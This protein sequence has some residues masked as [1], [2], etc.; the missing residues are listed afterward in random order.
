MND[1]ME[2]TELKYEIIAAYYAQHYEELK[3]FVGKRILFADA[4]EDIV[5]N[6]F[7]RLL[8]L[9]KMI[10][11]VT[12]PCL[13]YTV[14]RNLIFDYWRHH[15]K[16]DEYE[17]YL[18]VEL[19]NGDSGKDTA[20]SVYSVREITE[21]LEQG[22]AR[23]TEKQQKIY[24]MNMLENKAVKEISEELGLNYKTVE[25]KLGSARKV[26][27]TYLKRMMA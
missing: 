13:V 20:E 8:T 24:A 17:H 1:I 7:L 19:R 5:Q 27:R 23:L 4:T 14:A 22:M 3:N 2:N 11:E 21:L 12:L 25:N 15:Q 26:V 18:T 6:V 9:D 16:V 10:S